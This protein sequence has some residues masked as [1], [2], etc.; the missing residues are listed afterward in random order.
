MGRLKG[1]ETS[2][3][4]IRLIKHIADWFR[5][6]SSKDQKKIIME[7]YKNDCDDKGTDI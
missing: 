3:V 7:A 1:A 6:L 5:G 4:S 2:V